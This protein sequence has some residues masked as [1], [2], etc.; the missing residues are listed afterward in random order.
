MWG[1]WERPNERVTVG[2]VDGRL[3]WH[4]LELL[5]PREAR[6][7][8]VI[9][10]VDHPDTRAIVLG[11]RPP[12]LVQAFGCGIGNVVHLR[13]AQSMRGSEKVRGRGARGHRGA[14]D[15]RIRANRARRGQTHAN[16]AAITPGARVGTSTHHLGFGDSGREGRS[17]V[18]A[19]VS[20]PSSVW[21]GIRGVKEFDFPA[22]PSWADKNLGTCQ[23][24]HP[25]C[26]S[27]HRRRELTTSAASVRPHRSA[28]A[29]KL[30]C[31]SSRATS[32]TSRPTN[33]SR[34]SKPTTKSART[35]ES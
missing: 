34:S 14:H 31:R 12:E 13:S 21:C 6:D 7:D 27:L 8:G 26:R 24:T 5:A 11:H 18:A 1:V 17:P 25:S 16:A 15:R 10:D 32:S 22:H 29:H 19:E 28:A 9:S 4:D 3:G 35:T 20:C 30:R 23:K 2:R 33:P